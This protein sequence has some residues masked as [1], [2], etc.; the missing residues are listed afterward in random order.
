MLIK[1]SS[2]AHLPPERVLSPT[3]PPVHEVNHIPSAIR[4]HLKASA[5]LAPP[6]IPRVQTFLFLTPA[7]GTGQ[8]APLVSGSSIFPSF[9]TSTYY[10]FSAS[11]H[12]S[13]RLC[14]QSFSSPVFSLI[15]NGHKL[16]SK[17]SF[18]F[19]NSEI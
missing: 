10:Y 5:A 18:Y 8:S 6:L 13:I 17:L 4:K 19:S 16:R 3:P 15:T 2:L 12:A 7:I 14:D 9:T 11:S 1:F